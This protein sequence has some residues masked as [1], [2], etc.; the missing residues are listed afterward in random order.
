[1]M[2]RCEIKVTLVWSSPTD[3]MSNKQASHDVMSIDDIHTVC[4]LVEYLDACK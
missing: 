2:A 3:E 1:M 4:E